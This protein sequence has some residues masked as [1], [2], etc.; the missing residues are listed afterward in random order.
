[1]GAQAAIA[2]REDRRYQQ[3]KRVT[4]TR[5][6][7]LPVV[8]ESGIDWQQLRR[9]KQVSLSTD[10]LGPGRF[11]VGTFGLQDGYS[12]GHT[13]AL[14]GMIRQAHAKSVPVTRLTDGPRID[15]AAQVAGDGTAGDWGSDTHG[16][17][18]HLY[19]IGEAEPN[20]PH[21]GFGCHANKF[22]TFDLDAVRQR[23]FDDTERDL[24][25]DRTGGLVHL[26]PPHL[27]T[28]R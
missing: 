1:M 19:L 8:P 16:R 6:D 7:E 12:N 5:P 3:H 4:R 21:P 23:H 10:V 17:G 24:L 27:P 18:G 26:V 25:P 28:L 2:L 22:I 11:P 9:F 14:I 20:S 15:C 13:V